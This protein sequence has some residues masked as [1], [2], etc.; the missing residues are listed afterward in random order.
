MPERAKPKVTRSADE[1]LRQFLADAGKRR[2]E[3]PAPVKPASDGVL[4]LNFV[5]G[6]ANYAID[7]NDIAEIANFRTPTPVP[8]AEPGTLG[9][10]SVRGSIVTLL[11]MRSKLNQSLPASVKDR[12]VI[13]IRESGGL[14]GFEVDRVLGV[15]SEKNALTTVLDLSKL[16][17]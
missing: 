1:K 14:I 4:M 15:I 11:D 5:L 12:R 10:M 3:R 13:I 8:N 9:I 7:I 17:E 16:L 6:A 2:F